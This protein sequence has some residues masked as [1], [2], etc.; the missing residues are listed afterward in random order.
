MRRRC[1]QL[2]GGDKQARS[3]LTTFPP[4]Q[5]IGFCARDA[6]AYICMRANSKRRGGAHMALG[7]ASHSRAAAVDAINSATAILSES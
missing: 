2:H 4:H 1:S 3:A 6:R 7:V 5:Q